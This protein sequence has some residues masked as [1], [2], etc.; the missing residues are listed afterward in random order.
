[1]TEDIIVDHEEKIM[2]C[3][4]KIM[5]H[6]GKIMMRDDK[7]MINTKKIMVIHHKSAR[8]FEKYKAA[9]SLERDFSKGIREEENKV[10]KVLFSRA[11]LCY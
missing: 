4:D 7:I 5:M 11:V 3:D 1:M 6:Q 9:K 8:F 2:M 10:N